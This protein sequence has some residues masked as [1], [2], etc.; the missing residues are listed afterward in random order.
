MAIA[1]FTFGNVYAQ[2]CIGKPL[3]FGYL[4]PG[5]AKSVDKYDTNAMCFSRLRI[6]TGSYMISLTLPAH[7]SN[8]ASTLPM[9][10]APNDAAYWF[11]NTSLHGPIEHDPSVPFNTQSATRDVMLR[12]G[13]TVSVPLGSAPGNYAGTVVIIMTRTGY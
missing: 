9:S 2:F 1:F 5:E 4:I 6:V 13:G 3:E 8:G 7:L 11:A 12:L 10:F